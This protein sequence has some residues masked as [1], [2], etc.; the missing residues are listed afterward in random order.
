MVCIADRSAIRFRVVDAQDF[1]RIRFVTS[2]YHEMQGLRQLVILPAC[3]IHFWSRPFVES[4]RDTGSSQAVAGFF[5]SIL[6][7]LLV[8]AAHPLLNRYYAERFGSVA[9]GLHRWS[10]DKIGWTVLILA[11]LWLDL[12]TYGSAK[13][14][15]LLVAGALIA[16]HIVWR[17]WPWRSYYLVT[18]GV[19]SVGAWLTVTHPAFRIDS[20]D[21]V[22]R[23]S[24][25]IM[26]VAH[27]GAAVMDHQLLLRTLSR[28]HEAHAD[29]LTSEHA[30]PV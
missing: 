3:L 4:L 8:L 6:P 2:R 1:A 7:W 20:L 11:G 30:D 24:F 19:C 23:V 22:L 12:S 16:L 5:L 14:S 27:T 26:I 13:P 29:A 15:G 17:D 10:A 9:G 28:N 25:T 18:A 21:A